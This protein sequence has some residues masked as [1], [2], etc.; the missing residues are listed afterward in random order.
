MSIML[1]VTVVV[2]CLLFFAGV[3]KL[4]S[5]GKLQ[6]KYSL[7]WFLF[8]IVTIVG[9]VFPEPLFMLGRFLGFR[10]ASNF[11]LLVGLLFAFAIALSLTSTVSRQ[12]R[13]ITNLVQENS[14]L[15][16]RVEKLERE[17]DVDC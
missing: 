5:K 14:L 4:I 13:Y 17:S 16:H 8:G 2:L 12:S 6:L 10:T 9:A 7:I 11:L 15:R 1:R 3:T